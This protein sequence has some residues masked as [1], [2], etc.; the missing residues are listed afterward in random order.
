MIK[1]VNAKKLVA[2]ESGRRFVEWKVIK[3]ETPE[4]WIDIIAKE[5]GEELLHFVWSVNLK[6]DAVRPLSEAAR[7]LGRSQ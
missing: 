6:T 7:N 4:I 2:G 3:H 1:A 5:V